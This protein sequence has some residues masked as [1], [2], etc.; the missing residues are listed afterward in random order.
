MCVRQM[1]YLNASFSSDPPYLSPGHGIYISPHQWLPQSRNTARQ[2][3]WWSV[4][5]L[6]EI[7]GSGKNSIHEILGTP[8]IFPIQFFPC[9]STHSMIMLLCRGKRSSIPIHS[10]FT[11]SL[12]ETKN[13]GS[14]SVDFVVYPLIFTSMIFPETACSLI[15]AA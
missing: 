7:N 5:Q 10:D 9:I 11:Q 4:R 8:G 6:S 1:N 12:L 14:S 3:W 2:S 13:R 15:F